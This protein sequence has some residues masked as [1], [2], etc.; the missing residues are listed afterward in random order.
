MNQAAIQK[1]TTNSVWEQELIETIGI[2]ATL[3]L[4]RAF[5]VGY[6]YIPAKAP[7]KAIVDAIG[8][9]AA[10]KL[11]RHFGCGDIWVPRQ[12][13]TQYRN[14]QIV[15]GNSTGKTIHELAAKFSV[16]T[17]NIRKILSKK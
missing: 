17:R 15:D 11:V 3:N 4:E 7:T 13:L 5:A 10:I 16:S 1:L 14:I 12:L 8:V 6:L 2:E 9:D